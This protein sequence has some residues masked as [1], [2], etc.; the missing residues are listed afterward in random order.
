[1]PHQ[2]VITTPQNAVKLALQ[3]RKGTLAPKSLCLM[4]DESNQGKSGMY[5][6]L[7]RA[8]CANVVELELCPGRRTLVGGDSF[9]EPLCAALPLLVNLE[10][11]I[12]TGAGGIS[13]NDLAQ[14]LTSWPKLTCLRIPELRTHGLLY[15]TATVNR[16]PTSLRN[17]DM[18]SQYPGAISIIRR[19]LF[20]PGQTLHPH[21]STLESLKVNLAV[22]QGTPSPIFDVLSSLPTLRHLSVLLESNMKLP[23]SSDA[24]SE[25]FTAAKSLN[26]FE[27]VEPMFWTGRFEKLWIESEMSGVQDTARAAGVVLTFT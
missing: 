17:L 1:M 6:T 26:T 9:G 13:S 19:I 24:L 5:G 18:P 4:L 16:L 21:M 14:V 11:F 15:N 12:T 23:F 20:S 10:S 8:N 7:L 27:I 25:F 2:L 3:I 22:F